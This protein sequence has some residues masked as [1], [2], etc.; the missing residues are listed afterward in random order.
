MMY[1]KLSVTAARCFWFDID[2][3]ASLRRIVSDASPKRQTVPYW[4]NSDSSWAKKNGGFAN[5][6]KCE[7]FTSRM[8]EALSDNIVFDP[9]TGGGTVPAVCK[10]LGRNYLAFEIDP[11]TAEMARQRV[12]N[13]QP[14]LF[15]PEAVQL[16]MELP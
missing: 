9:F 15:V 16:G 1:G 5:W 3:N 6:G 8:I 2:G 14:P 7:A 10:M 13:T 12:A 11:A 4:N